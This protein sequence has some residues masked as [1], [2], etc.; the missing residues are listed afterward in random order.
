MAVLLNVFGRPLRW[1]AAVLVLAGAMLAGMSAVL[2]VGR[3]GATAA[4]TF[5]TVAV[6]CTVVAVAVL[7][8]ARWALWLIVVFS[9][10][11]IVAV[12][13]TIWELA[14]GVEAAKADQLRRLGFDPTAGVVIN[15]V[16][17]ALAVVLFG[18]LAVRWWRAR[19]SAAGADS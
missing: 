15:L 6:V 12:I 2:S 8:A 5:A 3:L 11:Q 19:R 1:Y 18:C 4:V 14:T 13:G 7:H 17:S 16:Y 9:G 10:G